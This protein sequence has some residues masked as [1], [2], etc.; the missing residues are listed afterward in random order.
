M[1]LTPPPAQGFALK[2]DSDKVLIDSVDS[3]S[4]R[5]NLGHNFQRRVVE[6]CFQNNTSSPSAVQTILDTTFGAGSYMSSNRR[7][8]NTNLSHICQEAVKHVS[9]MSQRSVNHLTT[10]I[11][12]TSKHVNNPQSIKSLHAHDNTSTCLLFPYTD[13]MIA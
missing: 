12:H 13:H 6:F 10:H 11:K 2:V 5:T 7:K 3:V 4:C 1:V 9:N 8:S